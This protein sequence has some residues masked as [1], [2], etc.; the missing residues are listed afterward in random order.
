MVS[1]LSGREWDICQAVLIDRA[2]LAAKLTAPSASKSDKTMS[3]DFV[4]R[5]FMALLSR[6]QSEKSAVRT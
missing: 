4:A 6:N 3:F 5:L 2:R 1:E